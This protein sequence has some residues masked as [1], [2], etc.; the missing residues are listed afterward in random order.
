MKITFIKELQDVSAFDSL[1]G[2][3]QFS[4]R[5]GGDSLYP[6]C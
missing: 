2:F 4:Y 5:E 3:D 6:P 1:L